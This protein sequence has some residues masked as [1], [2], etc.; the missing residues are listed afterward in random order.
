MSRHSSA[1]FGEAYVV[2]LPTTTAQAATTDTTGT[3]RL[4]RS[5]ST[6]S[7]YYKGPTNWLSVGS[8]S[9]PTTPTG[10]SLELETGDPAAPAVSGFFDNFKVNAGM[11]SCPP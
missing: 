2:V 1:S 9:V 3:I 5:G 10:I 7:G 4:V 6:S 11:I 8:G